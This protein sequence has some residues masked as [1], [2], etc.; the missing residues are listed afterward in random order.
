MNNYYQLP[1]STKKVKNQWLL[2]LYRY[3]AS[4]TCGTRGLEN[5]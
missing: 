3:Q 5:T 2:T 4:S 1:A